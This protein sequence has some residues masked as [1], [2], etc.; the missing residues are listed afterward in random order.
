MKLRDSRFWE[1]TLKEMHQKDVTRFKNING[2]K[3]NWISCRSGVNKL[4]Y[5]LTF[6]SKD[7]RVELNIGT[8]YKKTNKG[9]FDQIF[10]HK[11]KIES[12][13][14]H[15]LDWKRMNENKSCVIE[16]SNAIEGHN[17]ENWPQMVKWL[18]THFLKLEAAFDPE[19]AKINVKKDHGSI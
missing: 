15:A 5:I 4:H 3:V 12:V 17:E 11:N 16:H 18:V 13:Y 6:T 8:G 9:I 1:M 2:S 14:G 10:E 19:I 7:I